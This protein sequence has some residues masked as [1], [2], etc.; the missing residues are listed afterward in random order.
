MTSVK[1]TKLKPFRPSVLP[2]MPEKLMYQQL[3]VDYVMHYFSIKFTPKNNEQALLWV[4]YQLVFHGYGMLPA[5]SI[6]THLKQADLAQDEMSLFRTPVHYLEQGPYFHETALPQPL[7]E[8]FNKLARLNRSRHW[9][10]GHGQSQQFAVMQAIGDPKTLNRE[11]C[12]L[13]FNQLKEILESEHALFI[14]L[15]TNPMDIEKPINEVPTVLRKLKTFSQRLR[16]NRLLDLPPVIFDHLDRLPLPSEA[17]GGLQIFLKK[18]NI[19]EYQLTHPH[20][21]PV[22]V[23]YDGDA[24]DNIDLE[25]ENISCLPQDDT[26]EIEWFIAAKRIIDQFLDWLKI[27]EKR[28]KTFPSKDFHEL[29][30]EIEKRCIEACQYCPPESAAV[31]GLQWIGWMLTKDNTQGKGSKRISIPTAREYLT[32]VVRNGLLDLDNAFDL[33][34]WSPSDIEIASAALCE[35]KRGKIDPRLRKRSNELADNTLQKRQ[36]VF[37]SFL[38]FSCHQDFIDSKY[39]DLSVSSDYR[40]S[41]KRNDLLSLH[42]F[43]QLLYSL[44]RSVSEIN[45]IASIVAILAFYGGLRSGEIRRL[46]LNDIMINRTEVW[47]LIRHGKSAAARRKIPLHSL[48]PPDVTD[49]IKHYFSERQTM[50]IQQQPQKR[51]QSVSFLREPNKVAFLG[52]AG[53]TLGI[54][55]SDL[56][57]VIGVLRFYACVDLD[58]HT[59]RHSFATWLCI[60]AVLLQ[61]PAGLTLLKEE[62]HLLFSPEAK[63]R[64]LTLFQLSKGSVLKPGN[65]DLFIHCRKMIGHSHI[66][67]TVEHYLHA[68]GLLMLIHNKHRESE[69]LP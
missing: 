40:I 30:S 43:D 27:R 55:K 48:A 4:Y 46:T 5:L 53:S 41:I 6:L 1:S 16:E 56:S 44:K 11:N 8:V 45:T 31:I 47:I 33:S 59:L 14:E 29:K 10:K 20:H 63:Q 12:E 39:L 18:F 36:I 58:I 52:P 13:R 69:R 67:V 17:S 26:D 24:Q 28:Y 60:R 54:S 21:R 57:K 37:K 68:F 7:K 9:I 19:P 23:H 51:N 65:I 42:E 2:N 34:E 66:S 61:Y 32:S 15:M 49:R 3:A 25:G 38:K 50:A 35:R 62:G 22:H 64:F